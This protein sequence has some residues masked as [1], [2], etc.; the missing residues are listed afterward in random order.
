MTLTD[1]INQYHLL[2][3]EEAE[4]IN[5][6]VVVKTFKT[7]DFFLKSGERSNEVGFIISGVIRYFFYDHQGNE[8]TSF[9]MCENE[10]TGSIS[11]FFEYTPSSG[12]LQ[13]ECDCEMII[14]SRTSWELFS[15][16]ILHWETTFQKII[17]EVLIRKTSFQ[18]SLINSDAKSIYLKFLNSYPTIAQRVP[19]NHIASFLGITKSSLSRIRRAIATI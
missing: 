17:N 2:S 7:K 12:S 9:F 8:V 16:E 10:F 13:A 4:L 6:N 18:R 1:F 15:N 11:S 14:I 3:K 19:L 5:K